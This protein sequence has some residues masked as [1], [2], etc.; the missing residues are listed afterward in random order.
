ML[1]QRKRAKLEE[2][3]I[4]SLIGVGKRCVFPQEI[5]QVKNRSSK[6]ILT[7]IIQSDSKFNRR[8]SD[9]VCFSIQSKNFDS[10]NTD[11][12][13]KKENT[14]ELKNY[15]SR[16]KK[17]NREMKSNERVKTREVSPFRTAGS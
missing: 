9:F 14:W 13:K 5:L 4:L 12:K 7:T 17:E 10:D 8:T 1:S 2:S 16:K 11:K 3:N 15:S 6:Q